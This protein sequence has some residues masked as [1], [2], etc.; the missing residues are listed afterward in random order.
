MVRTDSLYMTRNIALLL[1]AATLVLSGCKKKHPTPENGPVDATSAPTTEVSGAVSSTLEAPQK[2]DLQVPSAA[3]EPVAAAA[4]PAAP[5]KVAAPAVA[6]DQSATV[7]VLCYHNVEDGKAMKSL[8]ITPE[9]FEKELKEIE[10]NGF[11]V[12]KMQ[13]FLAWRRG[14]GTIP[15]K[16]CVITLDDGWL[17]AYTNAWP[18]LKK[19]N[20]P[21]TV[22]IYVNYVGSGGKSLTW[23][24]LAEMRD[25]GVDIQS[26]TYSHSNLRV[27]GGGV[28]ARTKA[29]VKKDVAALGEAGWLRKEII[30]SKNVLE[31]QLGIKVNALAYPFGVYSAKARE[32][33]KEAGYE[34]AFTVYGQR[35]S[36]HSP[37]YD[38]LG[39]YAVEAS[40]P[41]I[42][43]D[44]MAMIGGGVSQ[45]SALPSAA[46]NAA[47]SM[48]TEPMNNSVITN[49]TPRI[50]A[51]LST[52][53]AVDPTSVEVFLSGI[54]RLKNVKYDPATKMLTGQVVQ[55]LAP[56]SYDVILSAKVNG[57]KVETRWSF[58]YDPKGGAA[59]S[60]IPT[61]LPPG[62]PIPPANV[63]GR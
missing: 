24:Q 39:R 20:Y 18:I 8:T 19:Y 33:V 28:D 14:A 6:I 40:K 57:E 7:I 36:M 41:K 43:E 13:D 45:E 15:H 17:S 30:E 56:K 44:A 25:A 34:A 48:I 3:S 5:A 63:L 37:P 1:I 35:L 9:E 55:K 47:T 53:G 49:P 61:S 38:L 51:N 2:P 31:K 11:T 42:F 10:A 46:Q 59:G 54:G 32:V 12:I 23:D 26:H 21:F 16:S 22:F 29:M 4:A 62:A 27:P 52:M 58:T 50:Q 60:S